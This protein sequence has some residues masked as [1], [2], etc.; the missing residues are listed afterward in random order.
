[1]MVS[2]RGRPKCTP[3]EREHLGRVKQL[4]CSACQ[5]GEQRSQTKVHHLV[6]FG[7]RIGHFFV[8]PLCQKHHEQVHL[9]SERV[10]RFLWGRVNETLGV[11]REWPVSKILP[12]RTA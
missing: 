7:K 4:P 6:Y 8:L 12:R 3:E 1:M 10:R 2:Y 5:A 11:Q 9:M